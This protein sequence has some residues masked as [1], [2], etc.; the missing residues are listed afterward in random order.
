[1]NGAC[2]FPS[3]N[4]L[5]LAVLTV[6]DHEI[7]KGDVAGYK[8]V[9]VLILQLPDGFKGILAD[10]DV[11][12]PVGFQAWGVTGGSQAFFIGIA[13]LGLLCDG[14]AKGPMAGEGS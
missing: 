4:V 6:I 2:G 14:L 9:L 3:E 7:A 5:A 11:A 10:K 13:V 8:V 1:M 12:L